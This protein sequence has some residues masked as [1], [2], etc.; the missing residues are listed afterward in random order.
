MFCDDVSRVAP[1]ASGAEG[2]HAQFGVHAH[3]HRGIAA[4]R[5]RQ[6]GV[7]AGGPLR[8]AIGS[9]AGRVASG[10]L[11]SG[12]GSRRGAAGARASGRR[13]PKL[14]QEFERGGELAGV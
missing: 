9:G 11:E 4:A 7:H 10:E 2:E 13:A 5:I 14:P 8:V 12:G 6:G 1:R 3:L